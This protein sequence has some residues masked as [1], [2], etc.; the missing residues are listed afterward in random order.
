M[1]DA[2]RM[3]TSLGLVDA[4]TL[5]DMTLTLFL[6][7]LEGGGAEMVMVTLAN[8]LA[9]QGWRVDLVVARATGAYLKNVAAEVHVVDL[10]APRVLYSLPA[11]VRYLRKTRPAVMLSALNYANVVA[12]WA[13]RMAGVGT[14]MV[15]SE[16]NNV[17]RDMHSEPAWRSWLIPLLM[18][19]SYPWANGIVAVSGGVAEELSR[20]LALPRGR[21]DVIYNPAV[22]ERLRELSTQ[23]LAHPWLANGEPPV[24][25]AVGR[26]TEQKDYPTLIKAFA[27]LRAR[28]SVRLVILG[29]GELRESLEALVAS[30]GVSE[31][32]AFLGFVDNPYAW[33]RQAALFVLSSAWEGFGNVLAEA[34]ACGTPVISTD[35]PSGP[36]EILEDGTW[37]QLVPVGDPQALYEA[38]VTALQGDG[39]PDVESRARAFDLGQAVQAYLRVMQRQPI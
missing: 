28:Q 21:I 1:D 29:E 11:L 19:H 5:G 13:T 6:P 37:G 14:R 18:R 32:V 8:G 12:L 20:A 38:M 39:Y 30:L 10:R 27:A 33:M 24:I 7:S 15:I 26:L 16:H 4:S 17:T 34:M 22:T 3:P 31:D 9:A 25:L 35:C 2:Q 36:A 23:A